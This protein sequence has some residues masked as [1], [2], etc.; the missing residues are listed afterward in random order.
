MRQVE[1]AIDEF[2]RREI[3]EQLATCTDKERAGFERIWSPD[4]CPNGVPKSELRSCL[5]LIYRTQAAR[6]SLP[7]TEQKAP[8]Q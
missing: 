2:L 6:A 8:K 4:R 3:A 7:D 5:Q 1:D